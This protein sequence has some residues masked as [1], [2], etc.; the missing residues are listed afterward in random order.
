MVQLA[1]NSF[2]ASFLSEADKAAHLA[3]ID[4]VVSGTLRPM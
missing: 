4:K 2:T 3:E 1:R